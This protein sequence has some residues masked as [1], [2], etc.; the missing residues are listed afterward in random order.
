MDKILS[1]QQLYGRLALYFAVLFG[2]IVVLLILD[3]PALRWLPLG[4]TDV[5]E[6]AEIEVS[7]EITSTALGK[8]FVNTRPSAP[9]TAEQRL[10]VIAFLATSIAFTIVIMLPITWTYRTTRYEAGFRKTFVRALIVL[11]VCATTIV[12]LIQ[13]SLALAFGLAALVAAVRFRVSLQDAIDGIYIFAAICVALAARIGYLGIAMVM[14]LFFCF[15]NALLW[16][17]DYGR[18]PLDDARAAKD[19]KKLG[20]G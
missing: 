14:A 15:A 16:H 8:E 9:V 6:M 1:P 18:N 11:P 7:R 17:L 3:S 19:L 2:G 5:L 10:L 12:L 13:D 20:S 4:G